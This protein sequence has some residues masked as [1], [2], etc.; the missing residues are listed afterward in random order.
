MNNLPDPS[1]TSAILIVDDTPD[2]LRYLSTMLL[3]Q[4]YRVRKA[5]SGEMALKSIQL[6]QPDLILLDIKMPGIDGYEVC[7]NL[8]EVPETRGIPVIFLSAMDDAMD[9]VKAFE[10]GGADYIT[11]PFRV[12]EVAI[13][14]E[15][16]LT[17]RRQQKQLQEKND[18][19]QQE[20]RDRAAAEQA[21]RLSEEKFAK[22]F[23]SS[24]NPIAI[25]TLADGRLIDVNNTFLK[26]LG[27]TREEAIGQTIEELNLW[28]QPDERDRFLQQLNTDRVVHNYDFKFCTKNGTLRTGLLSAEIIILEGEECVLSMCNDITE[29]KQAE[30]DLEKALQELERLVSSQ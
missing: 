19:L 13:R 20:I 30:T 17:I 9:K 28:H 16:Q 3:E 5:T 15:N 6:E 21:L 2:N 25:T 27:Y 26:I 22:V 8:K 23:Y 12:E 4:G 7:R 29:L 10:V 24:P 14:V 18:R 11:K 1:A